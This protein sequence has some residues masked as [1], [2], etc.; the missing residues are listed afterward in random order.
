MGLSDQVTHYTLVSKN[1]MTILKP[2]STSGWKPAEREQCNSKWHIHLYFF[3]HHDMTIDKSHIWTIDYKQKCNNHIV[4]QMA[5]LPART[6]RD[7]ILPEK[8]HY[9]FSWRCIHEVKV[10][11]QPIM[12]KLHIKT[13]IY[14]NLWNLTN[15]KY[16]TFG[17]RKLS[18]KYRSVYIQTI[19]LILQVKHMT[20]SINNTKCLK[21]QTDVC[22]TLSNNGAETFPEK[23]LS[24]VWYW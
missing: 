13:I 5:S 14:E 17:E 8:R 4:I 2:T 1:S 20:T 15:P 18:Q 21:Q 6:T 19:L 7:V 3:I 16:L 22:S 9:A 10:T 12:D 24:Q 11:E 23:Q